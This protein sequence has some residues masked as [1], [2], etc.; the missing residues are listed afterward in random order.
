MLLILKHR[1]NTQKLEIN[2]SLTTNN[3]SDI[4]TTAL[5]SEMPLRALV[6][7]ASVFSQALQDYLNS[8]L[9]VSLPL[10]HSSH[11]PQSDFLFRMPYCM[12]EKAMVIHS[13]TLAWNIPW[14][15]EPGGLQSMRWLRV[16]HD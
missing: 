8:I 10:V 1:D 11:C 16:G 9:F 3:L 7:F 12:L 6:C 14:T 13:S 2:F 5:M 4:D 15:E